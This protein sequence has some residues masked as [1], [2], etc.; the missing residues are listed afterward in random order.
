M[1]D[2]ALAGDVG[3]RALGYNEALPGCSRFSTVGQILNKFGVV[4]FFSAW[5]HGWNGPPRPISI[6]TAETLG[7]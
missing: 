2:M 6:V 4:S 3:V 5:S 1:Q 7:A